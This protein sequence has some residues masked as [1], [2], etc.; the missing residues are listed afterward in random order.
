MKNEDITKIL[1]ELREFKEEELFLYSLQKE[2]KHKTG[3]DGSSTIEEQ[4]I[5]L[6]PKLQEAELQDYKEYYSKLQA[7]F[8]ETETTELLLRWI[9]DGLKEQPTENLQ[10]LED[11]NTELKLRQERQ[12]ADIRSFVSKIAEG[13]KNIEKSHQTLRTSIDDAFQALEDIQRNRKEI[14]RIKELV[15]EDDTMS[16]DEANAILEQQTN[17]YIEINTRI[18]ESRDKIDE[19][20]KAIEEKRRTI[21]QLQERKKQVESWPMKRTSTDE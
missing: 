19:L 18:D 9:A 14:E 7:T 12:E 17:A 1:K 6:H 13:T 15:K 5:P 3:L 8:V 4:I 20:Q 2:Y 16:I 11:L 21:Q 10:K